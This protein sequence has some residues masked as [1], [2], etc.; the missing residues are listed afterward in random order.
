VTGP[1]RRGR[2]WHAGARFR[3]SVAI[4]A[5]TVAIG[6][7]SPV[8]PARSDGPTGAPTVAVATG[9]VAAG[10]APCGSVTLALNPWVGSEADVAVVGYVLEHELGCTVVKR[11]LD[12]ETSWQFLESRGVDAIL[13]NWDHDDLAATYVTERKVA[14]DAGPSGNEGVIG[15][16][17]P[18]FFV[19]AHPDILTAKTNPTILNTYADLFR[20]PESGQKG[21]VLDGDPGFVTEDRAMIKGF[22]L[23]YEVVYSGSEDASNAA[24]A[25]AVERRTPI[26]AYFVTPNWFSTKVDLVHIELPAFTPGCNKDP[27]QVACDYP[28]YQLNKVVSAKFA[29]SGSPAFELIRR[30]NWTNDD[31]DL[32]A[33]S[34]ADRHLSDDDAAK[35]W[36]DANTATWQAWL[37]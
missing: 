18:R 21:Q 33:A 12:D 17:T 31:Q 36:L 4:A 8:A 15:W 34:I 1:A 11:Q 6:A 9:P 27:S 14:Q 13:E 37:P 35:A 29:A 20:T 3:A 2:A 28:V 5:L 19:D 24:L 32:V 7:C 30:F 26:L 23:D 10:K 25:A 16:Y 22:G